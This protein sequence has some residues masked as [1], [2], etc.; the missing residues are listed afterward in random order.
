[1]G[2]RKGGGGPDTQVSCE[3]YTSKCDATGGMFA[4]VFLLIFLFKHFQSC[5]HG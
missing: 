1:M 5:K 2:W 4:F 3:G